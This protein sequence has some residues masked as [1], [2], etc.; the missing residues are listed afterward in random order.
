M[1]NQ[2]EKQYQL[3]VSQTFTIKRVMWKHTL[4]A[5]HLHSE[6]RLTP[7]RRG[8]WKASVPSTLL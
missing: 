2:T 8:Q 4:N 3:A 5:W 6:L 7:S 1:E